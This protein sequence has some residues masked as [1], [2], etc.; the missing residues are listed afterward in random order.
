MV[1]GGPSKEDGGAAKWGRATGRQPEDE[2]SRSQRTGRAESFPSKLRHSSTVKERSE[3]RE[4]RT[5]A[6]RAHRVMRGFRRHLC[7]RDSLAGRAMKRSLDAHPAIPHRGKRPSC[8]EAAPTSAPSLERLLHSLAHGSP[9]AHPCVHQTL[10]CTHDTLQL[11]PDHVHPQPARVVV[12]HQP[13][14]PRAPLVL[15]PTSRG[16]SPLLPPWGPF[17][18]TTTTSTGTPSSHPRS[19]AHPP[20][21]HRRRPPT[22]LDPPQPPPPSLVPRRPR[23]GHPHLA[24]LV[25]TRRVPAPRHRVGR[26]R[27]RRR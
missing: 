24:P 14:R 17:S 13:R 10:L 8:P 4:T 20:R 19:P 25:R 26:R 18:S 12:A 3:P 1:C 5:R 2:G 6:R 22:R 11:T 16:S 7:P 23:L 27:H 9:L 21:R 15:L